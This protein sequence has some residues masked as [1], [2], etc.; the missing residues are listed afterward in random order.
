MKKKSKSQNKSN[1]KTP[2]GVIAISILDFLGTA[3]LLLAG[4]SILIL[5]STITSNPEFLQKFLSDYPDMAKDLNMSSIQAFAGG[6]SINI[7][8]FLII[9]SLIYLFLGIGLLKGKNWARMVHL[10]FAALGILSGVFAIFSNTI[11]MALIQIAISGLIFWYLMY[12][13]TAISYFK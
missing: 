5:G 4:I 6:A 8:I 7:G 3:F 9:F 10:V 13:K 1:K 12:E 11:S 2:L